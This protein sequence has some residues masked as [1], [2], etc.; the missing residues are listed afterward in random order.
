MK[1]KAKIIVT[2]I[3]ISRIAF[4]HD[5]LTVPNLEQNFANVIPLETEMY[6]VIVQ[7]KSA[8]VYK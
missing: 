4:G 3:L 5:A 6:F 8:I 1:I 7:G 2:K